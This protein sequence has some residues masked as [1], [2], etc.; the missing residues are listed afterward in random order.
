MTRNLEEFGQAFH[1]DEE[2]LPLP[3]VEVI[4]VPSSVGQAKL[5]PSIVKDEDYAIY[6]ALLG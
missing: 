1:I 5:I 4:S 3:E 2:G 6:R